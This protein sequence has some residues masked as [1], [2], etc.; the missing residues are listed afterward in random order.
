MADLEK[1][2]SAWGCARRRVDGIHPREF[3]SKVAHIKFALQLWLEWARHLFLCQ[4]CP[5][6]TLCGTKTQM[7]I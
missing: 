1:A 3:L 6:Q 7:G 2:V 4:V 5:V